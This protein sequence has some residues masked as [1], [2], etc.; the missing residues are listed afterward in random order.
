MPRRY[1]RGSEWRKWDLHL[2]PPG[3][4]LSDGYGS[5]P[6]LDRFCAFL[7]QSDVAVFGITDYFSAD[8]FLAVAA[9]HNDL[10]PD[11]DKVLLPN[12]ELRLNETVNG[13]NQDVHIHLVLRPDVGPETLNKLLNEL[14]TTTTDAGG[15]HLRCTE[16]ASTSQFES[17]TVTR[18]DIHHAITETF[19]DKVPRDDNVLVI[20]PSNND[21]IRARSGQR[22]RENLADEIDKF[23]DA[24]YG[25]SAN[26]E[27]FLKTDRYG[28]RQPPS[29]P[30]PVFA[31]SDAHSF[32]E[33][34]Q[35]LGKTVE[36]ESTRKQTTWIKADPTFEGLQQTL[37]EPEHRVRIQPTKPDAKDPYKVISAVHFD[38]GG[39]PATIVFNPN[40]TSIIG[41][42]SSGKSALMAYIAHA[43][44]PEYTVAQQIASGVMEPGKAGPA[45][46][47]TWNEVSGVSCTVEWADAAVKD[48]KIIY[49]PQNSLFAVSERPGEITD[50][51]QPVLYRMDEGLKTAHQR[52][53]ADIESSRALIIA[54]VEDW[55][56]L[57]Q[58]ITQARTEIR[59]LGDPDAISS[60][61]D[62]LAGRVAELREASALSAEDVDAYQVLV[63]RLAVNSV[64]REAIRHET[65]AIAP[66]LTDTDGRYA[67]TGLSAEIRLTPPADAFPLSLQTQLAAIIDAAGPPLN[68]SINAAV[69]EYQETLDA[70]ALRL[71]DE[72]RELRETNAE[73]I[74]RNQANVELE[75]VVNAHKR[76]EELLDEIAAKRT[77]LQDVIAAQ[78]AQVAVVEQERAALLSRTNDFVERFRSVPYTLD[79]MTFG[80]ESELTSE[81]LQAISIGF[82]RQENTPYTD[83]SSEMVNIDAVLSDPATFL[84]SLR[85]GTQKLKVGVNEAQV[86]ATALAVSP[87]V[88]FIATLDG[89][90]IGGFQRSSMTPGKQALFALTL[91]LNESDE[92]WPLLIDQ[93]EDDLDSRSIFDTIVPYLVQRK[94]D[95]QILM[96]SH[97]ANLVVGADSEQ[98]VVANRHA[99]DRQNRDGQA[100]AYLTGSLEHSL[101]ANASQFVLESCGVREHACRILDGGE[102]AFQK[103]RDKYKI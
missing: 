100:F 44:D 41:S 52:M 68:A 65:V 11:S 47:F 101:A 75:E 81:A 77:A 13:N 17:A 20:V 33:L 87:E 49:I 89:D 99:T 103:R 38:S 45:A 64:R 94:R 46:G 93:P 12:I 31:C 70:E 82:N 40:L 60:T 2:H 71:E 3:T 8:G 86:A 56:R 6:E 97:D 25:N 16:L 63:D 54:A 4:K 51:I 21:G 83:R 95:R 42:R 28:D 55:F 80:V 27:Y 1:D 43:V 36:N 84:A 22:R 98:V 78:D 67:T 91:I 19:G 32:D 26:T 53:H 88:R 79:D 34:E 23:A 58:R 18:A 92:T 69:I 62:N 48:G 37:V 76:Q 9:R 66:Y 59:D 5:P 24:I 57:A 30:K 29:K 7:E 90:R 10:Y 35:W 72:E 14:K 15:R 61:R 96:V 50:K 85:D 102:T 39:F 73:L 74:A